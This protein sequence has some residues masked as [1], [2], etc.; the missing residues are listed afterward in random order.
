MKMQIIHIAF[1][2]WRLLLTLIVSHCISFFNIV[3]AGET[4]CETLDS[5][6]LTSNSFGQNSVCYFIDLYKAIKNCRPFVCQI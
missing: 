1:K 4:I 6:K 5:I 2:I 3:S